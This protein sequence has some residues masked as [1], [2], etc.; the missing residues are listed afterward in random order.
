MK[1]VVAIDKFKGCLTAPRA[2]EIVRGALLSI[3]PD[4]RVVSKP[5][6]DGGD[7]TAEVFHSALGGEWVQ[8]KVTGPLPRTLVN[9]RYLWLPQERLAVV[10][11]AQASG[12]V[13]LKPEQRNPLRTHSHGTGELLCYAASRGAQRIL[14]AVGGSA[15]IDGGVGAARAK[16]WR[17]V[18]ANGKQ[19]ELG[20]GELERILKIEDPKS[21]PELDEDDFF[22]SSVEVLC[23]VNNPL[24]GEHGAAHEFG[25]QKG[26]T[27]EMVEQLDAGLRHLAELVKTQLGKDIANVPGAGAAGGL[28]FGALAFMDAKLIP[29]VEAVAEA[30][31]LDA[32]LSDADWVITGEGRFDEQSLRGKVVSGI[33]KRARKHAVK[34]AV[35]AGRVQVPEIVWRREGI[36]VV[37]STMDPGM[38]LDEAMASA[39]RLL[40]SSA[41]QFAAKIL[42]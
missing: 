9:A 4:W 32:E 21:D 11:M 30:I 19:V 29:G 26:A 42:S 36:E 5:M 12:L 41:C 28:A 16:G 22:N 38:K 27:P 33:T 20:G 13:L 34:V 15:T 14:L 3:H 2:C 17:F 24:C 40:A 23:D 37:L 1:I 31:G 6:A 18:G 7:G 10:E 8:H 25:P 39:E 35:I